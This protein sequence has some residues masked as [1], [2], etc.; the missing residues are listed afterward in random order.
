MSTTKRTV[1]G[2]NSRTLQIQ[3]EAIPVVLG[4]PALEP[5]RLSGHE[6]LNSLFEYELLL[7]TPYA[8]LLGCAGRRRAHNRGHAFVMPRQVIQHH[9]A[10]LANIASIGPRARTI[11]SDAIR[12]NT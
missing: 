10:T 6:G 9:N 8:G 4:R 12:C 5:V 1:A 7:K 3:S 11:P 2:A